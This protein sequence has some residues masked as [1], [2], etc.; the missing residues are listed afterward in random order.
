[1][2]RIPTLSFCLL[3]VINVMNAQSQDVKIAMAQIFCLDGD[4]SGNFARIEHA[5]VEASSQEVDIVCFPETSLLG[6]VNPTAHQRAHPIPGPDSE[7]LCGLAK[8]YGVFL[9][10]GLAEK[11]GDKLYDTVLLIDP[12]GKILLKHRK[13]NLLTWLMEPPYTPGS[14]VKS[15]ETPFGQVGLMICADSFDDSLVKKMRSQQPDFVLI[16]YGWAK[17]EEDWPGHGEEL[18]KTVQNAARGLNCPVVGT[19]LIGEISH[20]PWTGQVYG[21]Q[22]IAV[23]RKGNILA[24]GKDRDRDIIVFTLPARK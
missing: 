21:G 13:I 3:I 6:W 14:E 10:V 24:R 11:E 16:P 12:E 5:I 8:K 23:D 20:G 9:C 1:M 22:S 4:R 2:L 15:I 19:D 18:R 7:R 17:E